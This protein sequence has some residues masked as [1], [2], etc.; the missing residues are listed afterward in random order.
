[1]A[2]A[3]EFDTTLLKDNVELRNC[4]AIGCRGLRTLEVHDDLAVCSQCGKQIELPCFNYEAPFESDEPTF[5]TLQKPAAVV[6]PLPK[7]F[8]E[9]RVTPLDRAKCVLQKQFRNTVPFEAI[10]DLY[11]R[12][13][14]KRA[15]RI[16]NHLS[17]LCACMIIVSERTAHEMPLNVGTVTNRCGVELAQEFN[18]IA[19]I[20]RNLK[21]IRIM[22]DLPRPTLQHQIHHW[23]DIFT[24]AINNGKMNQASLTRI[25][26]QKQLILKQL[27][28]G[29]TRLADRNAETVAASIVF[30]ALKGFKITHYNENRPMSVELVHRLTGVA[31]KSIHETVKLCDA[32]P[33]VLNN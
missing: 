23:V 26:R 15:A 1:M 21:S 22:L 2:V 19:S 8:I 25:E 18:L 28:S 4:S 6:K 29:A 12:Y 33:I 14:K 31:T 24:L 30:L 5:E 16:N 3:R 7:V 27:N 20:Q 13:A 17:T 32:I 9:Q 11:T 10:M